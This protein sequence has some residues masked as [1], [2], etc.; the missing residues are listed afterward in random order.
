MQSQYRADASCYVGRRAAR[1]IQHSWKA[2]LAVRNTAAV[3]IQAAWR[4]HQAQYH[5]WQSQQAACT[6]QVSTPCMTDATGE[7]EMTTDLEATSTRI[8][9]I[10]PTYFSTHQDV[11]VDCCSTRSSSC[12]LHLLLH[13]LPSC[14]A[15]TEDPAKGLSTALSGHS[16]MLV[17]VQ[18]F[19]RGTSVRLTGGRRKADMRLRLRQAALKATQSTH[20]QL[21]S[22]TKAALQQLAAAKHLPQAFPAMATLSMCSQYSKGCCRMIAGTVAHHYN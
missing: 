22:Q 9:T 21:G 13:P 3:R 10:L 5:L 7:L 15:V 2:S 17:A 11:A 4:R 6:L 14:P 16:C 1:L 8:L 20:R 12:I 19:W 18:A